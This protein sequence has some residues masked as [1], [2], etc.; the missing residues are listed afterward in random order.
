MRLSCRQIP[1][2]AF[3]TFSGSRRVHSGAYPC[4][5]WV[6]GCVLSNPVRLRSRQVRMP[7]RSSGLFGWLLRIPVRPGGR[8][9]RTVHSSAHYGLSVSCVCDRSIPMRRPGVRGVPSCAFG[10]FPFPLGVYGFV[11]VGSVHSH[12]PWVSSCSFGCVRSIPVHPAC[13]RVP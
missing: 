2:C 1:L 8:R 5:L 9:L 12:S 10:P 7:G 6:V 4:A 13:H 3:D 11:R